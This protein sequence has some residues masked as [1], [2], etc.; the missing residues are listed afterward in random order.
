MGVCS[1][2]SS[3]QACA[4][5]DTKVVSA[6]LFGFELSSSISPMAEGEGVRAEQ[7]LQGSGGGG[8]CCAMGSA[9]RAKVDED[10]EKFPDVVEDAEDEDAETSVLRMLRLRMLKSFFC[11]DEDAEKFPDVDEDAEDEDAEKSLLRMLRLRMLKGFFCFDQDAAEKFPD[12][13]EDAVKSLLRML[14]LRMLNSFFCFVEDAEVL[15]FFNSLLFVVIGIL[16]PSW[17]LLT[18]RSMTFLS[19]SLFSAAVLQD[20]GSPTALDSIDGGILPQNDSVCQSVSHAGPKSR[21]ARRLERQ[22]AKLAEQATF[23]SPVSIS[24]AQAAEVQDVSSPPDSCFNYCNS[25]R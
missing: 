14:R 8:G 22:D 12:V 7:D 1:L 24:H 23:D 19:D 10:A 20:P 6:L 15:L 13:D 3:A 11:F 25:S 4:P 9:W 18:M 17:P 5:A 2:C 21:K 16:V